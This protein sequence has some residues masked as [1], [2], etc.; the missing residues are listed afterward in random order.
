MSAR[1]S[2]GVYS[3]SRRPKVSPI[4]ASVCSDRS[5]RDNEEDALSDRKFVHVIPSALSKTDR[6]LCFSKIR[7]KFSNHRVD[8]P[9]T[10]TYEARMTWV[11]MVVA[12]GDGGGGGGRR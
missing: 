9:G 6:S 5:K 12:N 2:S 7:E 4:I 8:S 11:V 3:V 1:E 10:R